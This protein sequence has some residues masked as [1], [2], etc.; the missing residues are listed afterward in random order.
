MALSYKDYIAD[1][2]TKDFPIPFPYFHAD[3]VKVYVNGKTANRKIN[4]KV[5]SLDSPPKADSTIRVKRE[6]PLH[7]RA[8]D[9]YD[10]AILSEDIL[11]TANEQLFYVAQEVRDYTEGILKML[12]D[13]HFTALNRRIRD[14]ADPEEAKD[15]VNL[16][17]IKTKYLPQAKAEADRAA[18]ERIQTGNIYNSTVA[19]KNETQAFHDQAYAYRNQAVHYSEKSLAHSNTSLAYKDQAGQEVVKAQNEV[20]R[21]KEE[22]NR[23]KGEADRARN[24]VDKYKPGV[25]GSWVFHDYRNWGTDGEGAGGACIYNDNSSYN[26]LMIAGNSSKDGKK[27]A[28]KVF[29]DLYV[30]SVA[31]VNGSEVYH[32]GNI[33]IS[34]SAPQG[35]GHGFIWFKYS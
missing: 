20:T 29:D 31:Y 21:A 4:N 14:V 12:E 16:G 22:A 34:S 7:E 28:V 18:N 25:K 17:F 23:A 13:G 26:A 32:K 10:G 8:V 30:H 2:Q 11:D 6:T 9:F 15:A 3:D 19:V 33:K 5:V 27:R 1:G 24:Y 35:G